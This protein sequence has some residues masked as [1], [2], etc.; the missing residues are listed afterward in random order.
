MFKN[1]L[2][3]RGCVNQEIWKAF[4]LQILSYWLLAAGWARSGTGRR[5]NQS[6]CP[7]GTSQ[8]N[9][10]T[11]STSGSTQWASRGSQGEGQHRGLLQNPQQNWGWVCVSGFSALTTWNKKNNLA[12]ALYWTLKALGLQA[13]FTITEMCAWMCD[14]QN[15]DKYIHGHSESFTA[16]WRFRAQS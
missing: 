13:H 4:L 6:E 8:V 12:A 16:Q 11:L 9:L 3:G 2:P 14:W 1:R 7:P 5:V 10:W 15:R